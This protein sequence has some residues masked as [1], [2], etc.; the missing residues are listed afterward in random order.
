M[1]RCALVTQVIYKLTTTYQNIHVNNIFHCA[2]A[3]ASGSIRF[4]QAVVNR[5]AAGTLVNRVSAAGLIAEKGRVVNQDNGSRW[6]WS[7]KAC[8]ANCAAGWRRG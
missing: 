8:G 3:R 4:K 1:Q 7:V 2:V 5:Q 6:R